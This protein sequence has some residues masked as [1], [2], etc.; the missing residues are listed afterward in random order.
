M[1]FREAEKTKLLIAVQ[2]QR[3]IEKEAETDRKK[4]IIG[5][6]G[7]VQHILTVMCDVYLIML[8]LNLCVQCRN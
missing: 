1:C 2:K 7:D 4:A 5:R 8:R 3:V 6:Q